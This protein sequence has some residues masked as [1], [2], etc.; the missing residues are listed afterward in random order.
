VISTPTPHHTRLAHHSF[1]Q[2]TFPVC[3][4]DALHIFT[5]LGFWVGSF[6]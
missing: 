1:I 2:W 3:Q 6:T 5:F 4:G